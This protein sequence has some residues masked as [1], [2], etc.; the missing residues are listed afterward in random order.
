MKQLNITFLLTM[1]M[2]MIGIQAFAHDIEVANADGVTIYYKY[3]N[4][5]STKLAVTYRGSESYSYDNEYSGNVVIPETVTYNGK[6]YSVT[7]IG[8]YAF[9][10]CK[11]LTKVTIPNSVTIV[12]EIAFYVYFHWIQ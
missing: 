8:S 10:S 4:I 2:S 1:L 5:N 12:L 9:Y 7:S 11:G 6:T 3:I